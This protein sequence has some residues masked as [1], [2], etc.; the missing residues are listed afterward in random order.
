MSDLLQVHTQGF[1]SWDLSVLF[2]ADHTLF[3]AM[4]SVPGEYRL[5]SGGRTQTGPGESLLP[6]FSLE[7][8]DVVQSWEHWY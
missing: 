2:C 8:R 5:V 6:G 7:A 4:P 1:Q 3:T